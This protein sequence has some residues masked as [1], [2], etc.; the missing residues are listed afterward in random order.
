[1]CPGLRVLGA[2]VTDFTG[3]NVRVAHSRVII[4]NVDSTLERFDVSEW[5]LCGYYAF[6]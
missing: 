3:E 2:L 4:L 5:L 1:M 6:L